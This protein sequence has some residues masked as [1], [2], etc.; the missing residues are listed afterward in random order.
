M[1]QPRLLS[2]CELFTF[3]RSAFSN[4]ARSRSYSSRKPSV[5]VA[6]AAGNLAVGG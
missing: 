5:C 4:T 3:S 2:T 1:T 6:S